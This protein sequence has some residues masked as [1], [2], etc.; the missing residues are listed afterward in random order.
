MSGRAF[1]AQVVLSP[2][3]SP[4]GKLL[5]Q[6]VCARITT[7]ETADLRLF[8]FDRHNALYYFIMNSDEQIYMR[9][10]GRDS[11]SPDAYLDLRSLELALRQGLE[12]HRDRTAIAPAPRSEPLYARDIPLLFERTIKR[13]QCVECHLIADYQLQHREFEGKLDAVTDLFASPDIK[14][15]GIDLNVPEGLVVGRSRGAAAEAGLRAGDTI[16]H[17]EGVR[18]RTFGDLQYRYGK[19]PR[20][21]ATIRL[22]VSRAAE[23]RTLTVALPPRWWY[24]DI[25]YRHWTTDPIVHFQSKPL[26]EAEKRALRLPSRSFASK[27]TH[28][29]LFRELA[30]PELRPGDII[31]GVDEARED[32]LA[33]TAELYIKL[34][35]RAGGEATLHLL[36]DGEPMT[37]RLQIE[38]QSFRK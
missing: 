21:A 8:E 34:H 4:R 19:V 11:K 13:N 26:E 37:S 1:D 23:Q 6:Y 36:R 32:G 24:S 25:A 18:V 35:C 10:G 38:R 16:T 14:V 28:V 12:M 9:Y 17:L 22:G 27:V 2:P 20:D 33:D 30:T 31:V 5:Q 29:D 15:V 7:M 3:A